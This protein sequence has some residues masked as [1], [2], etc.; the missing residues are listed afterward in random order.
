MG[1]IEK[2]L[3]LVEDFATVRAL[4]EDGKSV[5]VPKSKFGGN[6]ETATETVL[7]GIKAATKTEE[8]TV[9]VKI[10]PTTGKLYVPKGEG[11][12][13]DDEDITLA[14]IDGEQKLQLKDKLYNTSTY[15]GLG[16]K[17]LRKNMVD[18]VNVMN[19]AMFTNDDGSV[20]SNTRYV[21]QY[22]YD[23]KGATITVPD[24]CM[25]DFQG[26]S[27]KNGTL[28]GHLLNTDFNAAD[29]GLVYN[30]SSQASNNASK[31]S[32][33][34][35]ITSHIKLI[36]TGDLYLSGSC[37]A[38][39][40]NLSIQGNGNTVT[41]TGFQGISIKNVD[42]QNCRIVGETASVFLELPYYEG[43]PVLRFDNCRFSGNLRLLSSTFNSVNKEY[44]VN[45]FIFTNNV[46]SDCCYTGGAYVIIRLTD[47]LYR[48]V[49]IDNNIVHNFYGEVFDLAFTNDSEYET[50]GSSTANEICRHTVIQRNHVYNDLDYKP[51]EKSSYSA[52]Y[53]VT[54][55]VLEYGRCDCL[56]NRFENI[57]DNNSSS[58]VYDN[59]LSVSHL[60]YI[61]NIFKNVYN[62]GSGENRVICKS[63]QGGG[64]RLYRNNTFVIDDLSSVLGIE[65]VGKYKTIIYDFQS[66]IETFIFEYN[67]IDAYCL[68]LNANYLN[69]CLDYN[70]N[71]N[72]IKTQLVNPEGYGSYFVLS[73]RENYR[74]VIKGN[75]ITSDDIVT[76]N[77]KGVS[78]ISNYVGGKGVK[79]YL[80]IEDNYANSCNRIFYGYGLSNDTFDVLSLI[81]RNCF[82][83]RDLNWNNLT[84][85][86]YIPHGINIEDNKIVYNDSSPADS[87]SYFYSSIGGSVYLRN[88]VIFK[89]KPS[90]ILLLRDAS[91]YGTYTYNVFVKIVVDGITYEYEYN[92]Q[93]SD[94]V[95]RYYLYD[96][97]T[98]VKE[99]L[100]GSSASL[101]NLANT[102]ILNLTLA[103]SSG[104]RGEF[105]LVD[106]EYDIT[107][108][109]TEIEDITVLNRLP[110]IINSSAKPQN[111]KKGDS[112]F[113]ATIGKP[114]WWNG[115]AWVDATG[116]SV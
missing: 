46:I 21:I 62:I 11:N 2:D 55:T 45:S 34:S 22:D 20:C 107:I 8:E 61:G 29:L 66:D 94:G 27:V 41:L 48:S 77:T 1:K 51:W 5:Q 54:F 28:K 40:E 103:S 86:A 114:V 43:N 70:F 44:Y 6:L 71:Y 111:A 60:E 9:E 112:V 92:M 52:A 110:I 80:L 97:N 101:P 3:D 26:G 106:K 37:S 15:S 30:D 31:L 7:G 53:Y 56:N 58:A 87:L 65:D 38:V 115:S 85:L 35:G 12:P 108:S 59:Y 19:Q 79:G 18:G 10:E 84:V 90:A 96:A 102:N 57:I 73:N 42:M 49:I 95:V 75:Y 13:P 78:F 63:K 32:I 81:T 93:Y 64:Y 74:M 4:T 91:F 98:G 109:L 82:S 99:M 113:D 16:R 17:Y 67:T 23:L 24:G 72:T 68:T 47:T 14:E 50:V 88:K 89:N 104:L 105:M 39:F 69:E 76:E 116:A 25:L 100:S 33:L 36:I 83:I